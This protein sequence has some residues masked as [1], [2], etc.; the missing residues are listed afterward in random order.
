MS[1]KGRG[2]VLG[3]VCR[4]GIYV[5]DRERKGEH[6][7]HISLF[8]EQPVNTLYHQQLLPVQR[9]KHAFSTHSLTSFEGH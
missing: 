5:D 1:A 4:G 9:T 8:Y 6:N 3:S 7:K 2:G